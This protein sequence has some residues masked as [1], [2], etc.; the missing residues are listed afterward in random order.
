MLGVVAALDLADF[1]TVMTGHELDD[2]VGRGLGNLHIFLTKDQEVL[3][4]FK[5]R[6]DRKDFTVYGNF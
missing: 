6:G 5:S 3:F 4:L 2:V 1:E